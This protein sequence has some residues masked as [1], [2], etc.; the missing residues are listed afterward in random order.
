MN[1]FVLDTNLQKCAE[2][3]TD[4]HV[5]KMLTE[6]AQLLSSAYYSTNEETVAPYKL[7]HFKHPWAI[8][9]RASLSNW[10]WLSCL[11][12]HLYDEYKYRYGD[13]HHK[14]GDMI[15]YMVQFPPS[16]PTGTVTQMPLCMPE[17]C[18]TDDV[19]ASY[20][21]YYKRYKTHI[22]KWTKRGKPYWLE[23]EIE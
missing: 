2:Y 16:L 11:G 5:V 4:K 19:V 17:D 1:V 7:S 9:A 3:H 12:L 18:K 14:G 21:E 6:T 8:W 23:E 22:F 10:S 20:R 15:C 13:K